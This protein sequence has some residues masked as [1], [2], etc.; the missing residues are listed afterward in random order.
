MSAL[1]AL[2]EMEAG[3]STAG[4]DWTPAVSAFIDHV[5]K[6]RRLSSNTARNYTQAVL[7]FARWL[8]SSR[9][10]LPPLVSLQVNDA[11]SYII[12]RQR[13]NE[14]IGRRSLAMHVSA[15]RMFYIYLQLSGLATRNPFATVETPRLPKRLPRWLTVDQCFRLLEA[16][17]KVH[18]GPLR[19]F[20]IARGTAALEVLWGGGLRISEMLGLQWSNM[21]WSVGTARVLGKGGKERICP[22]GEAALSALAKYREEWCSGAAHDALVFR[23]AEDPESGRFRAWSFQKMFKKYLAAAGLQGDLTPHSLRHSFATHMLDAGADLRVVQE[24][25]GHASVLTTAIYCHISIARMQSVHLAA[26]PRG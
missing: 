10:A 13:G 20:M 17:A 5:L 26:H 2:A 24:L 12:G 18:E 15:L 23:S 11:R 16:P 21:D 22:L 25:L 7:D 1:P 6:E 9:G 3:G 14:I 8:W 4:A 19:R